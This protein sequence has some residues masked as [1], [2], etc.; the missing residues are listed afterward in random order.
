MSA[1]N[2]KIYSVIKKWIA[3]FSTSDTIVVALIAGL[4]LG[5]FGSTFGH[6]TYPQGQ[7]EQREVA[8]EKTGGAFSVSIEMIGPPPQSDADEAQIKGKITLHQPIN[9]V[10]QYKWTLP[11]GVSLVAGELEDEL[12]G[13]Q[14]GQTAEVQIAIDGVHQMRSNDNLYL[15][16]DAEAGDVRMGGTN[17]ITKGDLLNKKDLMKMQSLGKKRPKI[18]Q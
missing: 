4:A 10:P 5:H 12:P 18:F 2:S 8:S 13:L 6:K 17:S 3:E 11:E 1:I 14:P 16:V 9:A 7:P 15:T